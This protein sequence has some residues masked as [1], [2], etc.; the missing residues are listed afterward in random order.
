MYTHALSYG[1]Y[2]Y[3]GW[4]DGENVICNRRSSCFEYFLAPGTFWHGS[5]CLVNTSEHDR[6]VD[7][8]ETSGD[9]V[10]ILESDGNGSRLSKTDWD[11]RVFVTGVRA[12]ESIPAW[13]LYISK[14]E[15]RLKFPL[16]P[17]PRVLC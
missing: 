3:R 7:L 14:Q 15:N 8:L 17:I 6:F 10:I 9:N 4:L 5:F 12:H 16:S 11:G 1:I 13:L 2:D